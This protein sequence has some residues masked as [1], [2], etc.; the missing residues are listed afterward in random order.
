MGQ[1]SMQAKGRTVF[2]LA[3]LR[4]LIESF[5]DETPRQQ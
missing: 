4:V 2:L 5:E 3:A 1:V